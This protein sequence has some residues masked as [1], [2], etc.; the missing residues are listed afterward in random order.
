[1]DVH[2]RPKSLCRQEG[3]TLVLNVG[4]VPGR[5]LADGIGGH[6]VHRARVQ[7]KAPPVVSQRAHRQGIPARTGVPVN[8]RGPREVKEVLA[9]AVQARMPRC[10]H[11]WGHGCGWRLPVI[12][13][14]ARRVIPLESVGLRDPEIDE[15]GDSSVVGPEALGGGWRGRVVTKGGV[16]KGARYR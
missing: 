13:H 6:G 1:V 5:K 8:G 7:L 15:R 2:H 14:G 11:Q 9:A 4:R 10:R 12:D 3:H 16:S